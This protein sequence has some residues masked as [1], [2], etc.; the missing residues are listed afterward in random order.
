M[1]V[2]VKE[3]SEPQLAER[4]R[5]ELIEGKRALAGEVTTSRIQKPGFLLTGLLEE[6]HSDRVQIFGAAEIGYL[7]SLRKEKS[8]RTF[9][10]LEKSS[11]PAIIVTRV[12]RASLAY[13]ALRFKEYPA[14]QDTAYLV[15]RNRPDNQ[16][17]RGEAR[18]ERHAARRVCGRA[19]RWHSHHGK[20]RHRE[21]ERA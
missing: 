7:L 5:L 19:R 12:G 14:F 8:K 18:A 20:E 6:L 9:A 17:F 10:L 11:I 3:F 1:G 15:N 2:P 13:R 21:R 4:L 16:I